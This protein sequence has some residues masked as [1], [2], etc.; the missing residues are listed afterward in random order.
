MITVIDPHAARQA[1]AAGGLG[2]PHQGC[3]GR[4]RTWSRARP[5]RVRGLD[6]TVELI[7]P[8]RGRCRGCGVTHVL[9]PASLLP[10]RGYRVEVIG[11]ALHGAANGAGYAR[12]AT[13]CQAPLSTVRDW[14]RAARRG[15]TGLITRAVQALATASDSTRAWPCP[16]LPRPA[17]AAAA[18]RAGGRSRGPAPHPG[19]TPR[20]HRRFRYR[21]RLPRRD[22]PPPP[23]PCAAVR[24]APGRPRRPAPG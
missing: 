5:R 6:G 14:I 18:V 3:D 10:R 23:R 17:L 16:I 20:A 7:R 9:L 13:A 24:P 8:D 11:A 15:A 1:L 4:L 2:C 21:H 19:P 12:A 22:H